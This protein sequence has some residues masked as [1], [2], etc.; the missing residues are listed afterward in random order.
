MGNNDKGGLPMTYFIESPKIY[1]KVHM[2]DRVKK[3]KYKKPA[4]QEAIFEAKFSYD[5]FDAALPGQ[6]FER[7]RNN[8]PKKKNLELVTLVLGASDFLAK[9]SLPPQAPV[10][11]AWKSDDSELIQVGPGIAVA[12]R[13]KYSTW[14]DFLPGINSVLNAYISSANP[15]YLTR[16]GTRYINRFIIPHD[17]VN[18]GEYFNLGVSIPTTFENLQ[19]MDITFL[20]RLQSVT[21][22]NGPEFEIRTKFVTDALRPGETGN[23]FILDIDCY[24]SK[25][26]IPNIE[27]IKSLATQAHDT[28]EEVFESLITDKT[29]LLMEVE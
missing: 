14:E 3:R 2:K 28:L 1:I 23:G 25:E 8:Y 27:S 17:K 13:V 18:M 22:P 29:R 15:R 16:L 19:G 4:V 9:P 12:N 11:Q 20:H 7:L 10:M 6:V 24:H 21:D 5:S 26:I